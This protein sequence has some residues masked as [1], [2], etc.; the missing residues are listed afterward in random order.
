M[1]R[2]GFALESTL[3]VLVLLTVLI[4]AAVTS[5]VMTQRT[6]GV[7][8]RGS[9]V[10]YAAEAGADHIMSQ[11]EVAMNDGLVTDPELAALTAPVIPGFTFPAITA[12]RS[13]APVPRTITSGSYAGLVG[14]NQQIDITVE[15]RDPLTNRARDVV[16]VNAQSIPL[17]QFGVFYEG[18]LE[19]H[20]GPQLD[21]A[22][23]VHSNSNIYLSPGGGP[24][25]FHSLITTPDSLFLMRKA[26]AISDPNVFIDDASAV[27]HQLTFD[28]RSSG[29]DA[30]FVLNSDNDFDG[31]VMTAASGVNPLQLP[32]P[33]GMPPIEMIN[34]RNAGDNAQVQAVKFAW[35]A[36]WNMTVDLTAMTVNV[37]AAITTL[38]AAHPVPTPAEC[39]IGPLGAPIVRGIPNAFWDGRE[40]IGV[41]LFE[42]NVAELQAWVNVSPVARDASIIYIS[43]VNPILGSGLTDYPAVRLI[44]GANLSFPM[45]IATDRPLYIKGDFN[46]GVWRPASF[47]A[48]AIVILSNNWDDAAAA[49]LVGARDPLVDVLNPGTTNATPTAVWAAIAAG[50]SATPCDVNRIAPACAPTAPPPFTGGG[51]PNYGGGLEN[52]PR[53][54]ENWGGVTFTYRGSLV[55]LFD[56]QYANRRR[57]AWTGYYSPPVRD[58]Q[59]DTRF[60]DPANLPPGTPT[61]GSVVQTAFR[62]VY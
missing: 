19:I 15:A 59:F 5:A 55:S 22:G 36:T 14:L 32:L 44:N 54:L 7:D 11:L 39:L 24:T 16:S 52:F 35:K 50:H 60:R 31:R 26:A 53:F 29:S 6:S 43:F 23:W 33:V 62:P 57:W 47:L 51:Y 34:P 49:H 46:T 42:V 12:V 58:W 4:G 27:A 13:G 41:D 37:C 10:A 48:D 61:V 25:N 40:N 2:R 20:N 21:F 8:Y 18:D 30:Q 45:S 38:P 17:F 56:S 9:R 3:V 1:N 28:S